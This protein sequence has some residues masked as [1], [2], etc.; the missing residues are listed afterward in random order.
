MESFAL[1]DVG[2]VRTVNQDYVYISDESVGKLPNLYIVA[3]GMGGHK[4]GDLASKFTVQNFVRL[5]SDSK[6]RGPISILKKAVTDVNRLLMEKA[7]ESEEYSGMGTTLVAATVVNNSLYVANVGDSR[8]YI[9]DDRLIQITR[10]HS[11]VEELVDNGLMTRDDENYRLFKNRITRAVGAADNL[12][13]DFFEIRLKK[14]AQIL[15][16]SDGLTGMV[17]DVRI[18][19]ILRSDKGVEEKVRGLIDEAK[20]NGGKDNIGVVLVAI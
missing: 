18:E 8:L 17:T 13:A 3:D 6:L 19:R 1:T 15:M 5:V 9:L 12:M 4:A 11:F 14:G 10:D 20:K 2:V 7:E 16:C